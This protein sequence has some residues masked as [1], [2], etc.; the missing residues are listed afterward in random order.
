MGLSEKDIRHI[1][2]LARLELTDAEVRQYRAELGGILRYVD[3]LKNAPVGRIEPTARIV[4][5]E[6]RLRHDRV[7]P[8]DREEREAAL[9]AAPRRR[10]RQ[11]QVKRILS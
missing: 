2:H 11:L 6:N 7:E 5:S 10:G 4:G 9:H 8:W 1:A 3:E